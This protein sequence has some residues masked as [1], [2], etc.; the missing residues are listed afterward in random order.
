MWGFELLPL[1]LEGSNPQRPSDLQT[2]ISYNVKVEKITNVNKK[3]KTKLKEKGH[4]K[5]ICTTNDK[6]FYASSN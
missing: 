1:H 4:H 5:M 3:K 6:I 2:P